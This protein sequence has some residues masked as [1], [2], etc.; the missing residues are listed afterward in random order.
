V[1]SIK[2]SGKKKK[3]E[4]PMTKIVTVQMLGAIMEQKDGD[5]QLRVQPLWALLMS[6]WHPCSCLHTNQ[7]QRQLAHQAKVTKNP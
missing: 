1:K 4:M 7:L 5:M 3:E 6:T 2:R